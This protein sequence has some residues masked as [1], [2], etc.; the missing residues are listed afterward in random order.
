MA[1]EDDNDLTD[2]E[3]GLE[4]EE[5]EGG[6]P[7]APAAEAPAPEAPA[8]PAA[9]S[10][11]A[12]EALMFA[13][14]VL[15]DT[16]KEKYPLADTSQIGLSGLNAEARTKY[17]ADAEASHASE[18]ERLTKLGF[19][20]NPEGAEDAGQAAKEAML[21]AAWGTPVSGGQAATQDE[22]VMQA[23]EETVKAGDTLGTIRNMVGPGGLG[24]FVFKGK[25]EA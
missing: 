8:A 2:E 10:Q 3:L 16:A 25:R 1:D 5:G 9:P 12:V 23:I 22:K 15:A 24:K 6:E 19:V 4:G 7:E 17:L 21:Q 20:Y 14:G 18:L 11:E 13:Q